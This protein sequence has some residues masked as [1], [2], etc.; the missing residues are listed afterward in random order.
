MNHLL[1]N[2]DAPGL[3]Q[4]TL[5]ISEN[6]KKVN[7]IGMLCLPNLYGLFLRF[8]LNAELNMCLIITTY[9]CAKSTSMLKLFRPTENLLLLFTCTCISWIQNPEHK[10]SVWPLFICFISQHFSMTLNSI[11]SLH[12]LHVALICIVH[13]LSIMC[14]IKWR[15]FYEHGVFY[16]YMY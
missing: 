4:M 5:C 16:L 1:S 6:I 10:T 13:V 15:F 11:Y 8:S 9:S 7:L 3:W 2:N 14:L 12:S